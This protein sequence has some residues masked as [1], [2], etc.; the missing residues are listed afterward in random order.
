[1][2]A[3]FFEC[4]NRIINSTI[5]FAIEPHSIKYDSFCLFI[6]LSFPESAFEQQNT[7]VDVLLTMLLVLLLSLVEEELVVVVVG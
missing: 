6:E 3:R 7:V 5:G 1:V 2:Q 4:T